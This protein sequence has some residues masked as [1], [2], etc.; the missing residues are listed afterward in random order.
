MPTR[1]YVFMIYWF[2]YVYLIGFLMILLNK[3]FDICLYLKSATNK[4][5][6]QKINCQ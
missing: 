1:F 5:M 4:P 2:I 6:K 3:K